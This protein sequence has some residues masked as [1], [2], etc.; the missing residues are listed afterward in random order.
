MA[1]AEA[2]LKDPTPAW[3]IMHMHAARFGLH[4]EVKNHFGN[5][6]KAAVAGACC[7]ETAGQLAKVL[8]PF[9]AKQLKYTNLATHQRLTLDYLQRCQGVQW[10]SDDL[11]HAVNF[12]CVADS[13][14]HRSLRDRLLAAGRGLFPQDPLYP[15]LTGRAAMQDGPYRVDV[16]GV[17]KHFEMALKLNETAA[18]PLPDDWVKI[19]KQS[20]SMLDEAA[21][22]QR[23]T[24]RGGP[25]D[26]DD[27]YEEDEDEDEFGDEDEFYDDDE[28]DGS[29]SGPFDEAQ[30]K[31]MVPPFL[32]GALQAGRRGPGHQLRRSDAPD[33]D[34][35]VGPGG[36]L[37][38]TRAA[39]WAV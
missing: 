23:S 1:A 36:H 31:G 16:L 5:R 14:R 30:L 34:R 9:V 8:L 22:M 38:R 35:R 29:F 12:L 28:E 2:K 18:Q 24:F 26:D 13:W 19:A 39:A 10:N 20:M 4:R 11:R 17:R 37:G 7:S 25:L 3:M 27:E 15:F 32:I 33:H 21:E 6:F